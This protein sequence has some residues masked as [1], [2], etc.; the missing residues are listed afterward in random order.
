MFAPYRQKYDDCCPI[1]YKSIDEI[2]HAVRAS[3]NKV[4]DAFALQTWLRTQNKRYVIPGMNIEWVETENLFLVSLYCLYCAQ[5]SLIYSLKRNV[6]FVL[7][8]CIQSVLNHFKKN[9]TDNKETQTDLLHYDI[10]KP[11]FH[12]RNR[13]I[14]VASTTSAFEPY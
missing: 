11:V 4:Y 9:K 10:S 6:Y 3:D 12:M 1:S 5:L 13:K 14:I 2:L 8:K 7:T